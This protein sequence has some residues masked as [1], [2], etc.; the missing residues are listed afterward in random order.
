MRHGVRGDVRAIFR[1]IPDTFLCTRIFIS[2]LFTPLNSS[3]SSVLHIYEFVLVL[4][5]VMNC[6]F[7]E[8][9][10]DEIWHAFR[11]LFLLGSELFIFKTQS[12]LCLV[13]IFV[14]PIFVTLTSHLRWSH[15]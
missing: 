4:V 8:I 9:M 1:F 5:L 2:A 12:S 11:Q 13:F 10:N 15:H 14:M 7:L 3:S 6:L